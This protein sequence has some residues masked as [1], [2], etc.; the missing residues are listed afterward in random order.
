MTD[1]RVLAGDNAAAVRRPD[2]AWEVLQ[3]A[4][5]DLVG[6]KTYALSRLLRGQLGTEWAMESDLESPLP[7]GAPFVLLNS[8][9][10]PVA[11]GHDE[12]GRP[13]QLRLIV[14]G[15][16]YSDP[17]TLALDVTPGA[18]A[19]TPLSPVHLRARRSAAGTT[20]SWVRRTRR[21]GDGWG[22][23]VPL[24]EEREA[25]EVDIIS[26]ASVVRTLTTAS[27]T[28]LYPAADELADFGAPQASLSVAVY[29]MSTT[30]GRGIAA[31]AT[32][33]L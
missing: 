17:A 32:L 16:D 14:S 26:G 7:A 5:A 6:P 21:G 13:L 24:G 25:Y 27:P 10:L 31:R 18:T 8:S 20:L 33:T 2:G 12:L 1:R 28:L 11:R 29:Q 30:I 19:L 9:L 23:E 22:V 15:R 4:N 3:F